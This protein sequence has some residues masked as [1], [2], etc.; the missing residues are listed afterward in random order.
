MPEFRKVNIS[1]IEHR[2]HFN[3]ETD[4][5][6]INSSNVALT[7]KILLRLESIYIDCITKTIF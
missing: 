6:K 5:K 4:L 2:Q 1:K 3:L 7:I